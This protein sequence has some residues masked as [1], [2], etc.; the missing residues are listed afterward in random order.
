[1]L[2]NTRL[3]PSAASLSLSMQENR[4]VTSGEERGDAWIF[5]YVMHRVIAFLIRT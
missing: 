4:A 2:T 5:T 1:V 3:T